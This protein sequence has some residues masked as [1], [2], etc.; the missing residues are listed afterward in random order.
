MLQRQQRRREQ[1][2]EERRRRIEARRS[3]NEEAEDCLICFENVKNDF[4]CQ[5]CLKGFHFACTLSWVAF[6]SEAGVVS[7]PHCRH[8]PASFVSAS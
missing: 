8:L 7:C 5:Q 6:A 3:S 4:R 1:L 2:L